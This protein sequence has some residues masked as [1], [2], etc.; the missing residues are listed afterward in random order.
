MHIFTQCKMFNIFLPTLKKLRVWFQLRWWWWLITYTPKTASQKF[1]ALVNML[2]ADTKHICI[3][4]FRNEKSQVNN[5]AC[6]FCHT[7]LHQGMH[8]NYTNRT[9]AAAMVSKTLVS[10]I[11]SNRE[12]CGTIWCGYGLA[13]CVIIA[14]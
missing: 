1:L 12:L 9:P 2:M 7:E 3:Y 14:F 11:K 5:D 6:K 8:S 4:N 13:C 10:V